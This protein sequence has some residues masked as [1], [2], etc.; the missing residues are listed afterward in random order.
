MY[1]TKETKDYSLFK[2]LRGNREVL[3]GHVANLRKEFDKVGNITKIKPVIVNEDMEVIDG[4][5]NLQACID[6][7]QPVFYTVIPG[8]RLGD[9]IS[10][11]I[12]Q[13]R[14]ST[15]DYIVSHAVMGNKNYQK[16]IVLRDEFAPISHKVLNGFISGATGHGSDSLAE[17]RRGNFVYPDDDTRTRQFLEMYRSVVSITQVNNGAFATACIKIF[18]QDNYRHDRMMR[19]IIDNPTQIHSMHN[20]ID[21]LRQLENLY[22][23]G[24]S[25]ENRVR[26]F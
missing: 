20:V 13:R 17:L 1:E 6:L 19:K 23:L 25:E 5:H 3:P 8:L 22:N 15:D 18:S 24:F 9:A 26:F 14:W 12:V 2:R 10:M 16:Y 21:N 4:Q 7:E 11:N